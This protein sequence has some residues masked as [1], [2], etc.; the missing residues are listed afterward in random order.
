[1]TCI[2]WDGKTLAGDKQ[3][4]VGDIPV[5]SKK[6][7]RLKVKNKIYLVGFSGDETRA[8]HYIE[9]FKTDGILCDVVKGAE[10]LVVGRY[11][12]QIKVYVLAEDGDLCAMNEK[13]WALGD[14]GDFALGAMHAGASAGD[15]V[16]IASKL[17]INSGG[18]VDVVKF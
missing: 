17:S 11:K 10:V 15:A 3:S 16:K 6:V 7:F 12:G 4:Q 14:A 1:M 5:K 8:L 2:A 9:M 13:R 18:G